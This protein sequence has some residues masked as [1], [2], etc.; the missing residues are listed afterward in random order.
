MVG[1]TTCIE[2]PPR[3]NRSANRGGTKDVLPFTLTVPQATHYVLDAWIW[4]FDSSNPGLG[5]FLFGEAQP[6][7]GV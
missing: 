3:G 4:R 6:T 1:F 2:S 5:S 7:H